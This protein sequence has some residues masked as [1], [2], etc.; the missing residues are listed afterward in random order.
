MPLYIRRILKFGVVGVLNTAIDFTLYI[1]FTQ[2]L[3]IW[4]VLSS[5]AS[6]TVG[7]AN[8]FVLNRVWTFSGGEYRDGLGYQLPVFLL[9]N[10]SGLL[11]STGT[12]WLA[13]FWLEP[14]PAKT[15]SILLTLF[16]NYWFSRNL[17]F[18]HKSP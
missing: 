2:I 15:V 8:S 3:T 5:L 17:V 9:A 10:V 6:Y 13:L 4:P 12:I 16:W 7:V 18:R 1:F 11:L 14:V